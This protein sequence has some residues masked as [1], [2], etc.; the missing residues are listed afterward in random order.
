MIH[1]HLSPFSPFECATIRS[2]A[3]AGGLC[4]LLVLTMQCI[5]YNYVCP[6]YLCYFSSLSSPFPCCYCS[7]HHLPTAS[8]DT[9]VTVTLLQASFI[10]P[11]G[12]TIYFRQVDGEDVQMWGKIYWVIDSPPSFNHTW[13]IHILAVSHV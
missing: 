6:I 3:E 7:P 11:M 1:N 9:D 10:S 5:Y 2:E 12:G 4:I 8:A 13:H